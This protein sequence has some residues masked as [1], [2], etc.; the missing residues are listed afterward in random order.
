MADAKDCVCAVP[1]LFLGQMPPDVSKDDVLALFKG[2]GTIVRVDMLATR[3]GRHRGCAMVWFQRWGDAERALEGEA[4]GLPFGGSKSLVVKFAD[5]PRRGENQT[6]VKAK[7]LFVGQVPRDATESD[8]RALFEPFG[9]IV[10]FQ[11]PRR[12]MVA[13][14]AFVKFAKWAQAEMAMEALDGQ[15]RF[16]NSTRPLVVKFADAKPQQEQS[17]VG[18]KRRLPEEGMGKLAKRSIQRGME[19]PMGMGMPMGIAG[20]LAQG[21]M[22]R[23]PEMDVGMGSGMGSMSAIANT[24]TMGQMGAL[25]GRNVGMGK[26]VL[27]DVN[28]MGMGP[29]DMA[30]G[31]GSS[32]DASM[33]SG[34]YLQEQYGMPGN[35]CRGVSSS[36]VGM[37]GRL[38]FSESSNV[39]NSSSLNG[40]QVGVGF[41]D[42]PNYRASVGA[43]SLA[44]MIPGISNDD[45]GQANGLS[46]GEAAEDLGNNGF[47]NLSAGDVMCMN[48]GMGALRMMG[49]ANMGSQV[50]F[51]GGM[52]GMG[53]GMGAVKQDLGSMGM[54]NGQH[55]RTAPSQAGRQAPVVNRNQSLGP[56]IDDVAAEQ[57]KL[58]V[59]QI[60]KEADE[61]D[62]WGVFSPIGAILELKILRK[63][64]QSCGCGF[65]TYAS[66]DLAEEAIVRLNG[67]CIPWDPDQRKL[68]VQYRAK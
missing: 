7:K 23:M 61:Y 50:A 38:G 43:T 17:N 64:G 45:G 36:L 29:L 59:G 49:N 33:S 28:P 6:G 68:V 54:T 62:L 26:G 35:G 60:S 14:C 11:M 53:M 1:K 66:Q 67:Q 52:G 3:D 42:R 51:M 65:V 47:T 58:F 22:G 8:V 40:A 30:T 24:M 9:E 13:G 57:W 21:S 4:G 18:D 39:L 2:Y 32:R 25:V 55:A 19:V 37:K 31:M 34:S 5:P 44:S 16:P 56:G 63:K 10:D 41:M 48:A 27:D 15:N 12:K 20:G 46:A